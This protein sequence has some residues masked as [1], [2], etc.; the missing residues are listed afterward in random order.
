MANTPHWIKISGY[1]RTLQEWCDEYADAG[2]TRPLV[3]G[4][5]KRG[6]SAE[7]AIT[8]PP[9]RYRDNHARIRENERRTSGGAA[10][11]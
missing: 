2:I 5:M 9:R 10:D 8:T 1:M 4:R 11:N 6:W 7:D 3:I